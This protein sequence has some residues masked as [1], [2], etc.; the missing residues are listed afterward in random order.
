MTVQSPAAD[1]NISKQ[2][3]NSLA[4]KGLVADGVKDPIGMATTLEKLESGQAVPT[5]LEKVGG[6][7]TDS[8]LK[9]M[10]LTAGQLVKAHDILEGNTNDLP[11]E[12]RQT[13][14]AAHMIMEHGG[15][16]RLK[17]YNYKGA[18]LPANS[19]GDALILLQLES[20]RGQDYNR[21]R[22]F[23]ELVSAGRT[24]PI[25]HAQ[26]LVNIAERLD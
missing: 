2:I 11:E 17:R 15:K 26:Q 1:P 10:T 24:Y 6:W 9:E 8:K 13:L 18:A 14:S 7:F 5:Q 22:I 20:Q 12:D 21:Q 16:F 23:L 3:L 4:Q 25:K 19:L